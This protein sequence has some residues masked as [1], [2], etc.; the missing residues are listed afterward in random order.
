MRWL[1]E[2]QA[3]AYHDLLGTSKTPADGQREFRI[4]I[5]EGYLLGVIRQPDGSR[6]SMRPHYRTDVGVNAFDRIHVFFYIR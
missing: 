1:I 2:V 4:G 3:Q 6:A 5:L